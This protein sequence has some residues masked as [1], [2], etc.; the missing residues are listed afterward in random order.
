M[1]LSKADPA[2]TRYRPPPD[3][4]SQ[5]SE[6]LAEW[7]AR[8]NAPQQYRRDTRSPSP[9]RKPSTATNHDQRTEPVANPSPPPST[10]PHGAVI[11]HSRRGRA[12]PL[13]ENRSAPTRH[14]HHRAPIEGAIKAPIHDIPAWRQ[15]HT[16]R[17]P[18]IPPS[19][20]PS[21][22]DSRI[23]PKHP[24]NSMDTNGGAARPFPRQI[25]AA[26]GGH[27]KLP[28]TRPWEP[29]R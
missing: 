17:H 2:T 13:R 5:V 22:T 24:P 8:A 11:R 21:P 28:R 15:H 7:H 12:P 16:K 19:T 23:R 9:T 26:V 20:P 18:P 27:A 6:P 29:A 1:T 10:G 4:I 3:A 14:I 25:G